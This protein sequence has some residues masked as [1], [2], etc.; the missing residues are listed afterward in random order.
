MSRSIFP[1]AGSAAADAGTAASPH[2]FDAAA[3]AVVGD[4]WLLGQA[5][6]QRFFN[7]FADQTGQLW[8]QAG[9]LLA[10]THQLAYY[11]E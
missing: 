11:K 9:E 4:G 2:L 10:T 7:N 1:A 5:Q 6:A 8:S 3:L